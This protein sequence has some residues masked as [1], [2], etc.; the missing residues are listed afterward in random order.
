MIHFVLGLPGTGKTTL[1]T[2]S[3]VQ[4][5]SEGRRALLIVPE[6]QTVE[7]ERTML[8]LLP[9][10]AQLSFEVL[11][12]S[13]LANKV[14][15]TYG[16]LSYH[17]IN[18]G[19]KQLLMWHTLRQL[20]GTLC[21]YTSRTANDTALPAM[22]LSQIEE[23]KAYNVSA[24]KLDSVLESIPKD[25]ALRGK[26]RDL[27]AVYANYES[28]VEA[29]YD[30]GADDLGKLAELLEEND[31]FEGVNVYI[32]SF[33]SFTAQEYRVL[34]RMF[35]Q[36]DNVTVS[37]AVDSPYSDA[38]ELSSISETAKK[39]LI[40][41]GSRAKVTQLDTFHRFAS[42]ELSRI[43]AS[44]W[45]FETVG[46]ELEPIPEKEQ[47]AVSIMRCQ[48]PYEEADAVANR[49]LSLLAEGYRRREIAVIARDAESYRGIIDSALEKAGISFFLSEKTDLLAKPLVS[50]IFSALAI[51]TRNWRQNDVIAYIKSGIP[52][53]DPRDADIFENYVSIWNI[54]GARFTGEAWTMNPEGYRS[55][56]SA[57][58][59]E[60]LDTANRVRE[61]LIHPLLRFFMYLDNAKNLGEQCEALR[62]FLEDIDAADRMKQFSLRALR[63]GDKKEAAENAATFRAVTDVLCHI[64]SALGDVTMSAEEFSSALRLVFANTDIGTIP[65]AADQVMI[66]SASMLRVSGVRC[67]I[68]M[69]VC[70]GEFPARVSERG[71]FS[72]NDRRMLTDLGIT[73][74]GNMHD[75]AAEE[76]LY[77]YRAMTLP[78]EKLILLYRDT[79]TSGDACYP[80]LAIRRVAELLPH[81][82]IKEYGREDAGERLMSL[83][84]AF[85]SLPSLVGTPYYAPL[86]HILSRDS[87]YAALLERTHQPVGNTQC[88]VSREVADDVFGTNVSLTQSRIDKYVSCQFSYY[89]RYVLD[90]MESEK[91]SFRF[92][93]SGTFIHRILEVFMQAITD[94]NGLHRD[95]EFEDIR[96]MVL[97]ETERYIEEMSGG[98]QKLSKRLSH[99]FTRLSRLAVAIAMDLYAEFKNSDFVPRL[100][101]ASIGN[102]SE[103]GIGSPAIELGDGSVVNIYGV[104]DRVDVFRSGEDVYI[105]VV[106]YKTGS[107]KFSLKDIE[108]GLNTQ[109]LLY[110]FAICNSNSPALR[111]KLGCGEDGKLKPAGAL[112]MS[113][114]FPQVKLDQRTDE[115]EAL[116]RAAQGIRRDGIILDDDAVFNALN[117]GEEGPQIAG[118]KLTKSGRKGDALITEEALGQLEEQ[119]KQTL[120]DIALE[121]KSGSAVTCVAN[122]ETDPCAYC[123]MKQ[124]CRAGIPT[125]NDDDEVADE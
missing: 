8:K 84:L 14:F 68:L 33:T 92:S 26:L 62:R 104:I 11:N 16:G 110:L 17:Y 1:I 4:D 43:A 35:A 71:V 99:L 38:A 30:D 79:T 109:L 55:A 13:R 57:R 19:M 114:A 29:A 106:D 108:K 75:A 81:L 117:H 112:Y 15:R 24:A 50:M 115:K 41:A 47:G 45:R 96:R 91:A 88:H 42:A 97:D 70:D 23:F 118:I 61:A 103:L 9:P 54:N 123:K 10:S 12:F 51:K 122:G 74:S 86:S 80:S 107:K 27:S 59:Q 40:E 48:S 83:P 36:A 6:Q 72:D 20:S 98:R 101:E 85:E 69:G 22:M 31:F 53:I 34:R 52:S 78:S 87:H 76:L 5:I 63:D 28:M 21:E 102:R 18:S 77:C 90:L 60:M 94:E 100:F 82:S 39:L 66:G 120:R 95:V 56:I 49:I 124:L 111:Q 25:S 64:A 73:L 46:K 3:I 116:K 65:T 44:L 58:G 125:K 37:L 113:T 89:C 7:T 121:M 67:A 93:D 2:K 32:D 105:K 119:L